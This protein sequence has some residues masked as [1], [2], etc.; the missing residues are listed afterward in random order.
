MDKSTADGVLE[1]SNDNAGRWLVRYR[2]GTTDQHVLV[3]SY[4]G[5]A[6]HHLVKVQAGDGS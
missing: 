5:M 6:T 3:L 2:P 4:R 1:A